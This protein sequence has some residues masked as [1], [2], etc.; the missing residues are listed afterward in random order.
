MSKAPRNSKQKDTSRVEK[1]I[2]FIFLYFT[3]LICSF[4]QNNHKIMKTP[5]CLC[6]LHLNGI[7]LCP[8]A[9]K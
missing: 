7:V 8:Y 9:F 3:L 4:P 5:G 6:S 2:I 1:C